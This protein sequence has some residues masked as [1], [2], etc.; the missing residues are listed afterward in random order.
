VLQQLADWADGGLKTVGDAV[1]TSEDPYRWAALAIAVLVP[2][3]LIF[4]RNEIRAH[5]LRVI[6]DFIVSYP[7]IKPE[8][9]NKDAVA[10][11]STGYNPS[12]EFVTSKYVSDL[13]PEPDVY[14]RRSAEDTAK[15]INK[16]VRGSRMF[17]NLGD[18]KLLISSIGFIALSFVGFRHLFQVIDSG[19]QIKGITGQCASGSATC[20]TPA[21]FYGEIRIVGA[22]AFAGAFIAAVRIFMRSLAVFDLSAYTFLRQSVEIFA[23]V[24]I[25]IFL[26]AAFPDPVAS[27]ESLVR[28]NAQARP[29]G[30][31]PWIWIT[32][33]PL[34]GLL[35]QSSTKFLLTRLQ[36]LLSW[37]KLDDDRFN[38]LTRSTPLDVIDGIDY[39]TRFRLE[40]C[41]IFDIQ[42]LAVYNPIMLYV[43]SPYGIYQTVDWVAQAQLCH[44]VGLERFLLLREM[45][46]R[47][48]FDLERAI[49]FKS[50]PGDQ[51]GTDATNVVEDKTAQTPPASVTPAPFGI[52]DGPDEFDRIYAGLLFACTDTMRGAAATSKIKP[53]VPGSDGTIKPV[54]VDD[55]C[56]WAWEHV[57]RDEKR[58]KIC[59][60]HLMAWIA[61]DLHVRRLRRIWQEISDSLGSRSERLDKRVR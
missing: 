41:G 19:L 44:I 34:L 42:N 3:I 48:I 40:E 27:L 2:I 60:E 15:E 55:Y 37:V 9:N 10:G 26:Y 21:V 8:G 23:S 49:D 61:D 14:T 28:E 12:L 7:A 20:C 36:S 38:K 46:V 47:T 22:L 25:V 56:K 35:P 43:E 39:F 11:A 4:A 24:L 50:R 45:H 29:C 18:Y 57:S 6:A 5:R 13:Q 51:N 58:L 52:V 59:V 17:G 53:L 30:A 31:L 33:A 16:L 54:D 1:F 32:L